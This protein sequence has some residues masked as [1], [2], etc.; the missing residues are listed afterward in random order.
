MVDEGMNIVKRWLGKV[1][2]KSGE[3]FSVSL[4]MTLKQVLCNTYT[5]PFEV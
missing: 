1:K 2:W 4:L 5:V 3:I